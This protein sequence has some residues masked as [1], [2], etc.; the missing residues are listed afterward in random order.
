MKSWDWR[1]ERCGSNGNTAS[2]P[3]P[4][5]SPAG[6][7]SHGSRSSV[8]SSGP[9][10]FGTWL[11]FPLSQRER[12]GVRENGFVASGSNAASDA[13][14]QTRR[15]PAIM[16]VLAARPHRAGTVCYPG[17]VEVVGRAADGVGAGPLVIFTRSGRVDCNWSVVQFVAGSGDPFGGAP[18]ATT[19][20]AT[21]KFAAMRSSASEKSRLVPT[22]MTIPA[23]AA[24][25]KLRWASNS[26]PFDC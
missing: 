19:A 9:G 4:R 10:Q 2:S 3:S 25:P 11:T 5:P 20:G 16:I 23:S 7:G 14:T 6:R 8:Q 15:A 18:S 24:A 21:D 22:A 12:A 1:G 26:R 13:F 17:V